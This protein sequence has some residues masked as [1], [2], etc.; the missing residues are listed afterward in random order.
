M[1]NKIKELLKPKLDY[2]VGRPKLAENSFI[3]A[4]KLELVLAIVLCVTLVLS[5]TSVLSGKTPLELIGISTAEKYSGAI[6][7]N[8]KFVV[9]RQQNSMCFKVFIP[10]RAEKNWRI[11]V[12]Y[13]NSNDPFF[14]EIAA[15]QIEGYTAT[16]Q[17]SQVVCFEKQEGAQREQIG[18]ILVK[19]TT[20]NN[21]IVQEN[22]NQ[23]IWK[24]FGWDYNKEIGWAYKDYKIKWESTTTTSTTTSATT[25]TTTKTEDIV[26]PKVTYNK[27]DKK[28]VIKVTPINSN[29]KWGWYTNQDNKTGPNAIW[30]KFFEDYKGIRVVTLT[31]T[32]YERQGKIVVTNSSGKKKD[33]YTEVFKKIITTTIKTTTT[34]GTGKIPVATIGVPVLNNSNFNGTTASYNSV[35]KIPISIKYNGG[36]YYYKWVTYKD[37]KI[38]YTSKMAKINKDINMSRTLTINGTRYGE[39]LI[40]TSSNSKNGKRI[41]KT[42]VYTVTANVNQNES[43]LLPVTDPDDLVVKGLKT[44]YKYPETIRGVEIFIEDGADSSSVYKYIEML[45]NSKKVSGNESQEFLPEYLMHFKKL[46]LLASR[47]SVGYSLHGN[48][49][50]PPR[51]YT[52]ITSLEN[53]SIVLMS[54]SYQPINLI[55]EAAHSLDYYALANCKSFTKE[56]KTYKYIKISDTTEYVN[57]FNYYKNKYNNGKT[58]FSYYTYSAGG[59]EFFAETYAM[60]YHNYINSLANLKEYSNYYNTTFPTDENGKK[61]K[62][63]IERWVKIPANTCSLSLTKAK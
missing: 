44:I 12:Y 43:N 27:T 45:R 41:L 49:N 58:Y 5:G 17:V 35:V 61:L 1:I 38:S 55:H 52:R 62:N 57:L 39:L 46:Y 60:Y 26:C 42:K 11:H 54:S 2:S 51:A 33:C 29:D 36:N 18:R 6:Q 34:K 37:G 8:N 48:T 7:L 25:T 32:S 31:F 30:K 20:G 4:V 19:W 53:T 28:E 3:K 40:Y 50:N 21:D 63:L 15:K 24:P 23:I 14:P 16:D 47:A 59:E 56:E 10:R 9:E 22:P 13:K